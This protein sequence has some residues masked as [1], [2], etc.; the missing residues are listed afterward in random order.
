M[1]KGRGVGAK[2]KP[3]LCFEL[4]IK[5]F[6]FAISPKNVSD[7]GV[8]RHPSNQCQPTH[9]GFPKFK[10]VPQ[11]FLLISFLIKDNDEVR[12]SKKPIVV[13]P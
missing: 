9:N 10:Q 6:H 12:S 2:K 13:K 4:H 8:K 1:K 7:G 5:T 3:N 11:I